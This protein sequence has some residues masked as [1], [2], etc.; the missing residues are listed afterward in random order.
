MILKSFKGLLTQNNVIRLNLSRNNGRTGYKIHKFQLFPH[1]I[2]GS[3]SMEDL[4]QVWKTEDAADAATNDA[5][6]SDNRLL[7]AGYYVRALDPSAP[8]V[9]TI[10]DEVTI[11]D[12][13]IFNQDIFLSYKSGQG[14]SKINFYLELE[15][16]DLT[17]NQE[18]VATLKDIRNIGV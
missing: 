10:N 17:L 18:T 5:D 11:F 3:T 9:A 8:Y 15:E 2:D 6:F 12:N 1:D 14:G 16:M 7:A 4:V 13:E